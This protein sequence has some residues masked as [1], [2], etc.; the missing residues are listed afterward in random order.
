MRHGF[1]LSDDGEVVLTLMLAGAV[2]LTLSAEDAAREPRDVLESVRAAVEL[3]DAEYAARRHGQ[4]T[5][6]PGEVKMPGTS[7]DSMVV[8]PKER[9]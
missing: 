6:S 8:N 4:R 1:T 3:Q 9:S 7:D 2:P 5:S